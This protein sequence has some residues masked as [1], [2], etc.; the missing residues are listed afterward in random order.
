L[1]KL[2][3]QRQSLHFSG[4]STDDFE[5]AM[6]FYSCPPEGSLVTSQILYYYGNYGCFCILTGVLQM[7]Q[8]RIAA[9][10]SAVER[11]ITPLKAFKLSVHLKGGA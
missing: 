11:Y 4:K 3:R 2:G 10:Q 6:Q 8:T 1:T 5:C 9:L 7:M